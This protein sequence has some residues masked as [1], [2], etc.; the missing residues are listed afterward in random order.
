MVLPA[1]KTRIRVGVLALGTAGVALTVGLPDSANATG[2]A[3]GLL[4]GICVAGLVISARALTTTGGI[5]PLVLCGLMF[6]SPLVVLVPISAA[7]LEELQAH[8]FV[9][10]TGIKRRASEVVASQMA[11]V[12]DNSGT[13]QKMRAMVD[14]GWDV[15][16]D[17][18]RPIEQFGALLD[19]GWQAK[20][21]LDSGISNNDIDAMYAL[22]REA[23]AIGG[24]LLGAGGGGFLLF[25]APP[26]RHAALAQALC[27][28]QILNVTLNAPGAEIVYS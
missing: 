5:A 27:G 21:S 8:L 7:R 10:F 15:L 24:K 1:H 6:T 3:L 26:E 11:R 14:C 20:R 25:F 13:L 2:I 17:N 23:G 9:A 4:A 16:T 19:Q 12:S 18:A 22:G 28:R